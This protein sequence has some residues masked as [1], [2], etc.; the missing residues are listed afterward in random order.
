MARSRRGLPTLAVPSRSTRV[1]FLALFLYAEMV[2]VPGLVVKTFPRWIPCDPAGRDLPV[3]HRRADH[4]Q[5]AIVKNL[6]GRDRVAARFDD[7]KMSSLV[8]DKAERCDT[9]RHRGCRIHAGHSVSTHRIDENQIAR[10]VRYHQSPSL[11]IKTHLGIPSGSKGSGRVSK[12]T[13]STRVAQVEP[14]DVR[15]LPPGVKDVD[16]VVEDGHAC[17]KDSSRIHRVHQDPAHPAEPGRRKSRHFPHLPPIPTCG[18][19]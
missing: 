8:E 1:P 12:R 3:G 10:P 7:Q 17:G 5:G 2:T 18:P 13:Q 6:V 19:R 14:R 9:A 11:W 15:R 16:Q 4:L